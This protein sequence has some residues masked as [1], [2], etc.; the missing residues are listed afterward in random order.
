MD[1]PPEVALVGG[2]SVG[3]K[4]LPTFSCILLLRAERRCSIG[5]LRRDLGSQTNCHDESIRLIP[6]LD[7]VSVCW[8]FEEKSCNYD[9]G[10]Q[11]ARL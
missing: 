11:G 1:Y 4:S 3:T 9:A 7:C 2:P 10:G 6:L 8:V 5:Q